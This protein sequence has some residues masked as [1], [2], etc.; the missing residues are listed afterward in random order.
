MTTTQL[1]Q[2]W[3]TLEGGGRTYNVQLNLTVKELWG[4]GKMP[5]D[6]T[7]SRIELSKMSGL[8]VEDGSYTLRFIFGGTQEQHSVRVEG[9]VLLSNN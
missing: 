9:G 6:R 1:E 2:V 4:Q 3:G 7:V 5:D 8:A